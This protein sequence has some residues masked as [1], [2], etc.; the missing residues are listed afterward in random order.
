MRLKTKELSSLVR[1]I[2]EQ[3]AHET[4]ASKK[5]AESIFLSRTVM[6][7]CSVQ[8]LSLLYTT[9]NQQNLDILS[10]D[11]TMVGDNEQKCHAKRKAGI[12]NNGKDF[13]LQGDS[14]VMPWCKFYSRAYLDSIHFL[15][16]ETIA[17]EDDEALPRLYV[18]A[19][20][21]SHINTI[22]YA[23]RQR[24]N[25]IMTQEISF[26]DFSSLI[27]I[28]ATY[29]TLLQQEPDKKFQ[30]YLKK[31]L[32]YYLFR[33]YYLSLISREF[34]ETAEI[35]N[36]IKNSLSLSKLDAFFIHNEEK[37]IQYTQVNGKNKFAHPLIYTL[38]KLRKILF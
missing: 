3:R 9:A 29:D 33:F 4:M 8:T 22:L 19:S 27:A 12:V 16:N 6:I 10:F 23:Y 25:S 37:F 36:E 18:Y 11:F 14:I 35:Y 20:R 13:L 1:K 15:Y 24:Q 38:R 30:N 34:P 32:Y 17:Y 26:K 5:H 31:R 21:V 2:A 28:I 7:T